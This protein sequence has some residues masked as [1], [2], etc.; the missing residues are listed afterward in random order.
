MKTNNSYPSHSCC[1]CNSSYPTIFNHYV[2]SGILDVA[3]I[4]DAMYAKN[5]ITTPAFQEPFVLVG[6]DSWKN[7]SSVHPSDLDP[8]NEIRLPWNPEFDIWHEKWFNV[9]IYPKVFLNQMSLLDEFLT[10]DN[11][12][13]TPLHVAKKL[14]NG[15]LNICTIDSGPA[16]EIVYYLMNP[17]TQ[18]KEMIT[19]FLR[20]LDKELCQI[21]GVHSFLSNL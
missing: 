16:N 8:R 2:E 6:A 3:L 19:H 20:L 18:K 13:I 17:N 21:N 15:T 1:Q 9:N 11:F 12:A 10:G 4:S 7:I 5:V 14:R